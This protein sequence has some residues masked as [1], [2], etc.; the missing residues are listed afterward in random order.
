MTI[1]GERHEDIGT[2]Q[3]H[4]GQPAGLRNGI[5]NLEIPNNRDVE[6]EANKNGA[7]LSS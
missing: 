2:S 1:P 7:E 3:E 6:K 4:D 5:H